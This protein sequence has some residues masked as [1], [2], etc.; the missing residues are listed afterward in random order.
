MAAIIPYTN[1]PRIAAKISTRR[2]PFDEHAGRRATLHVSFRSDSQ[3]LYCVAGTP[4]Q[5]R[6]G[7]QLS[8]LGYCTVALSLRKMMNT[9][10]I[11][12]AAPPSVRAV[13]GSEATK[14]PRATATMGL[15][16]A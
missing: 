4:H 6:A 5:C 15:T 11:T 13:T 8:A 3:E 1:I 16:Y 14:Y 12:S 2:V 10:T 7:R 9:L